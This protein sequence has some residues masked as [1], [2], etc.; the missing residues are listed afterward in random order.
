MRREIKQEQKHI[1][2]ENK[3]WTGQVGN[4]FEKVMRERWI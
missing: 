3:L 1:K 2:S 4:Y